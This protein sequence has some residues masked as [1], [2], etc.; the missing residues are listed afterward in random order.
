MVVDSGLAGRS[1]HLLVGKLCGSN[2]PYFFA[3]TCNTFNQ[4]VP[5]L[6]GTTH[7]IALRRGWFQTQTTPTPYHILAIPSPQYIIISNRSQK[8]WFVGDL[9]MLKCFYICCMVTFMPIYRWFW[10]Y[11]ASRLHTH[12]YVC[13]SL[14]ANY[15][16]SSFLTISYNQFFS[17]TTCANFPTCRYLGV[18]SGHLHLRRDRLVCGAQQPGIAH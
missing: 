10:L 6:T 13:S 16:L 15:H 9:H 18:S 7:P 8:P 17:S 11:Y 4:V 14:L 2:P 5:H 12:T 3:D 1:T